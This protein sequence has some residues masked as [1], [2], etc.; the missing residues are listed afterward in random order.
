MRHKHS[1][2]DHERFIKILEKEKA[3]L[4]EL[5]TEMEDY[6]SL[7][8]AKIE[9][10]VSLMKNP[11]EIW[12]KAPLEVC[13]MLQE[14]IFPF[15]IKTNLGTGEFKKVGTH[16]LSPLYSVIPQKKMTQ[17]SHLNSPLVPET[18]LEP[19]RREA[20]APK[21]YVYTNFTTRAC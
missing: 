17:M 14:M 1:Q 19:A 12:K 3:E 4:E 16:N 2:V 9:R 8:E 18:G 6:K 21:A 10:L 11:A 7:S 13:R 15:G 20:Y 5:L